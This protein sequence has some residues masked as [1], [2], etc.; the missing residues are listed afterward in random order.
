MGGRQAKYDDQFHIRK[1]KVS[2]EIICTHC[3]Q[4]SG[5]TNADL[6]L[7]RGNF[8]LNCKQKG[9]GK[10]AI[11]HISHSSDSIHDINPDAYAAF[12]GDGDFM[13]E[14]APIRLRPNGQPYKKYLKKVKE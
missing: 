5:F 2:K 10:V 8:T 6:I 3:R 11:R 14:E 9:C 7:L 4:P 12:Q 1:P 13:K